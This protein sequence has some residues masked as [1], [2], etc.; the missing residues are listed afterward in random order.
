MKYILLIVTGLLIQLNAVAQTSDK[1][2]FL[3]TSKK[4][5]HYYVDL[6][7]TGALVFEMETFS[8]GPEMGYAIGNI[9]TLIRQSDGA[10]TG[11][12]MKIIKKK[13]ALY[14]I[15]ESK[16]KKEM[17]LVNVA[18]SAS[19][20][21]HLNNSY[22]L[23]RYLEMSK[24]INNAFSLWNGSWDRFSTWQSLNNKEINYRAF[25]TFADERIKLMKDSIVEE[26]NRCAVL[27]N[28]LIQNITTINYTALRDS[29]AKLLVND[30]STYKLVYQLQPS[31]YFQKVIYQVAK[32]QPEF[33]FR[34]AEEYTSKDQYYIFNSTGAHDKNVLAKL[35]LVEGHGKIKKAFFKDIKFRKRMPFVAVGLALA[36]CVGLVLLFVAIF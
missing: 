5:N 34:L 20:N 14:L 6:H 24:E 25:R 10:Y 9:D 15:G 36:E 21:A 17:P 22:Y 23:E 33:F 31:A 1:S 26:Q 7:E 30:S 32:E 35:K 2:V 8:Q 29:V 16:K 27:M 18:D 19:A 13:D 11:R 3:E 4:A 28:Y 12:Q